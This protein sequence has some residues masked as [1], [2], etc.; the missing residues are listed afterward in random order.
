MERK[1]ENSKLK[2]GNIQIKNKQRKE[3]N[4][5]DKDRNRN[6]RKLEKVIEDV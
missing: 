3:K 2:R 4:V 5:S 1:V 6:Q